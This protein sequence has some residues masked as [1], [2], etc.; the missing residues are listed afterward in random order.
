MTRPRRDLSLAAG[1]RRWSRR[2]RPQKAGRGGQG[3]DP[4]VADD[5]RLKAAAE[6]RRDVP[7]QLTFGFDLEGSDHG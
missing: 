2:K 6:A 4:W 1:H 5:A 3:T 7:R